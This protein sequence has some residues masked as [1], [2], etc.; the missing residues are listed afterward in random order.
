MMIPTST[1]SLRKKHHLI[2]TDS[3]TPSSS[4]SS[5]SSSSPSPQRPLLLS[6]LLPRLDTLLMVLKTCSGETCTNPWKVLHP[7][8][9]DDDDVDDTGKKSVRNL[10]NALDERF[11]E[12]YE[13]RWRGGERVGF[14]R[15]EMGYILESEGKGFRGR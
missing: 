1:T 4:S 12:F 15:C 7:S 14:E 9:E 6:H 5:S 11:D 10:R 8:N 2:N 3:Q 13:G